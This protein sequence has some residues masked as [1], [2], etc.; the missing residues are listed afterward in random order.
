LRPGDTNQSMTTA[1]LEP[2]L[3]PS[4][5][6]TA[7]SGR[8]ILATVGSYLG[9]IVLLAVYVSFL[10]TRIAPAIS[11][12]DDNG[13]FA[14]GSLLA[15]TGKTWFA[16]QSDAQY[17]GMHWLLTP[18][19]NFI[20]RYPPGLPAVIAAVY[21][22]GG[23]RASAMVNPAL[24]V[25][26]LIGFFFL[27]RRIVGAGW[28]L[29]GVAVLAANPTFIRHALSGDSHMAVT[30]VLAWGLLMLIR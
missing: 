8:G 23:W 7:R 16:A 1:T 9:L 15:Q 28:S 19:G 4:P 25:I 24:S 30:A 26:A 29:V 2:S 11:D 3:E 20:S 5:T 12:P 27:A 22:F 17:I 18:A 13:Y 14:Q 21:H 10:V 6:R